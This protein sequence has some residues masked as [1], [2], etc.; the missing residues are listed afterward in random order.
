MTEQTTDQQ[1]PGR[2]SSILGAILAS[3]LLAGAI[4]SVVSYKVSANQ[5]EAARYDNR[6]ALRRQ[7]LVDLRGSLIEMVDA[8][9]DVYLI[10]LLHYLRTGEWRN[11]IDLKAEQ[12]VGYGN[13]KVGVYLATV[14]DSQLTKD[15]QATRKDIADLVNSTSRDQAE[16]AAHNMD[17]HTANAGEGIGEL[18][19][20]LLKG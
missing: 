18:L 15:V 7:S 5:I 20:P 13:T 16:A 11:H 10:N 19:G 17:L 6:T 12:K 2:L 3:S 4:S 8:A 14:D 1:R 9:K